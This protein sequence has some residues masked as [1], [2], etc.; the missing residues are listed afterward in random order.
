MSRIRLLSSP[1]SFLFPAESDRQA[2]GIRLG[3]K[4]LSDYDGGS[5][6][7][8]E[9]Y[10]FMD[11]T[12]IHERRIMITFYNRAPVPCAISDIYFVDGEMFSI[13]VQSV[14]DQGVAKAQ[15]CGVDIGIIGL[16]S[17][18]GP[19]SN[20]STGVDTNHIQDD[21]DAM[22]F[23]IKQNESLGIVF[24]LQA[25]VTLADILSALNKGILNISLKLLG[26]TRGAGGMLINDSRLGITPG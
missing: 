26:A 15:A 12:D 10:F 9:S 5:N 17:L 11:V 20:S 23:G 3:F 14:R 19:Y 6:C 16:Q 2:S 18:A 24:D 21:A 13:S 7:L 1:R 8:G 25:G 4:P 22:Q